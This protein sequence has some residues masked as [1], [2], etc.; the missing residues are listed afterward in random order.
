MR[1]LGVVVALACLLFS[2]PAANAELV[3]IDFEGISS[4]N[5]NSGSEDGFNFGTLQ[6]TTR[7]LPQ[8]TTPLSGNVLASGTNTNTNAVVEFF[9]TVQGS[10]FEFVSLDGDITGFEAGQRITVTGLFN[11]SVVRVDTFDVT[12]GAQTFSAVNLA[13]V[14]LDYISIELTSVRNVGATVMDNLV[15]NFSAVPEPSS[16]ALLGI[17]LGSVLGLRRRRK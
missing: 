9:P 11:S 5:F 1:L 2:A 14:T 10:T 15:L 16:V 6:G 17:G 4:G 3:T 7:I 12:T 8:A 13:G